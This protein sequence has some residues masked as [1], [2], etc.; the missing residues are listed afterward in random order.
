VTGN[1]SLEKVTEI[2][3]SGKS[4]RKSFSPEK[5]RLICPSLEIVTGNYLLQKRLWNV[6]F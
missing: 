6:T 3:P 2:T 5:V 4:D 1:S